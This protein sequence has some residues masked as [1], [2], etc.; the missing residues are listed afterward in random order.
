[1]TY[2]EEH[3]VRGDFVKL[4]RRQRDALI[5]AL[6]WTGQAARED[7]ADALEETHER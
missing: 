2:H 5:D 1:M 3:A 6:D 4:T 7:E